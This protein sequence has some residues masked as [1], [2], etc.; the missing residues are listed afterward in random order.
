M[1]ILKSKQSKLTFQKKVIFILRFIY[2][3]NQQIFVIFHNFPF[4][5]IIIFG[6]VS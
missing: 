1:H 4:I 3:K 2:F 6:K 5:I